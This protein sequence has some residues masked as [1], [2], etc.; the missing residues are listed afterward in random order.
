MEW[1]FSSFAITQTAHSAQ[2]IPFTNSR[3]Q[4]FVDC[5][6]C[7]L[8][9]LSMDT[10]G[11]LHVHYAGGFAERTKCKANATEKLEKKNKL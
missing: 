6:Q 8:R 10:T 11:H 1:K 9:T 7:S 4:K 3:N 5:V 2:Y